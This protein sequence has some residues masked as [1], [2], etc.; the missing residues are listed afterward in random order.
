MHVQAT[1]T[2]GA[3]P[4]GESRGPKPHSQAKAN[5]SQEI[6]PNLRVFGV[7]ISGAGNNLKVEGFTPVENFLMCPSTFL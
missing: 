6:D 1:I 7:G 5:S 4:R 2:T 3:S